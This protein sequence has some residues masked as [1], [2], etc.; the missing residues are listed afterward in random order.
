MKKLYI[1]LLTI[2]LSVVFSVPLASAGEFSVESPPAHYERVISILKENNIDFHIVDGKLMLSQTSPEVVTEVN[3]LLG[4]HSQINAEAATSYPTPYTHMRL[5]DITD[6]KKFTA[7][8]KQLL[9]QF[10]LLMRKI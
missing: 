3:N 6:S 1:L 10:L 4:S 7:A 8:T 2:C 5:Y 9:Q